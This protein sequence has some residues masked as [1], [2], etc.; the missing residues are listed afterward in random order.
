MATSAV[1]SQANPFLDG[2]DGFDGFNAT[3]LG[4]A[5]ETLEREVAQLPEAD[6]SEAEEAI[7]AVGSALMGDPVG[8]EGRRSARASPRRR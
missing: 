1:P 6:R 3:I 4:M 7:T 2:F 5:L 8:A